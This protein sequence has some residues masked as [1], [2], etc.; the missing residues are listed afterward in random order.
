MEKETGRESKSGLMQK[1]VTGISI[2]LCI[3]FRVHSVSP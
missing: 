1:L 3:V 2:L